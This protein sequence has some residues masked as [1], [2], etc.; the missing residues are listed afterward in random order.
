MC[1]SAS[2]V[3]SKMSWIL[4]WY[5][6]MW[7]NSFSQY[8]SE[9]LKSIHSDDW[10]P[11]YSDGEY[12]FV[13]NFHA[14]KLPYPSDYN[15]IRLPRFS[16]DVTTTQFVR[17]SLYPHD[18]NVLVQTIWMIFPM[19]LLHGAGALLA[20]RNSFYQANSINTLRNSN[21][22]HRKNRRSTN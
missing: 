16:L 9:Q 15:R 20:P 5:S 7:L 6:K 13:F 3:L 22:M 18:W 1:P 2:L 4:A 14:R 21:L 8:F 10:P 17:Y 12:N 19:L 11:C